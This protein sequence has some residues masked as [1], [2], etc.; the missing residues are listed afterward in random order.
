M[1]VV[2]AGIRF[3]AS[4]TA[5]NALVLRVVSEEELFD[6]YMAQSARDTLL[7]RAGGREI[8]IAC[9]LIRVLMACG[10]LLFQSS[11][12]CLVRTTNLIALP[13][14]ALAVRLS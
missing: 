11:A 4:S 6:V 13:Y 8:S 12:L 10:T 1:L 7:V 14:E 9:G 5:E 2:P 3:R